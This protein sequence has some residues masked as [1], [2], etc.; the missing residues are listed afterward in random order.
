[1]GE[2]VQKFLFYKM[3]QKQSSLS[4]L[5][6]FVSWYAN[7][8][9]QSSF[10][11]P[12]TQSTWGP[13]DVHHLT[14]HFS[15]CLLII[16]VGYFTVTFS[17]MFLCFFNLMWREIHKRTS[18]WV[19]KMKVVFANTRRPKVNQV[20]LFYSAKGSLSS[21]CLCSST[22]WW[23]QASPEQSNKVCMKLS[24]LS[25]TYQYLIQTFLSAADVWLS[26]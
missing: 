25:A 8:T 1:M 5:P 16:T 6:D 15:Y 20:I 7:R 21:M 17:I 18:Q 10:T 11:D 12:E 14:S 4:K 26:L 2:K 24:G 19:V 13:E 22:T 9:H 23:V 3:R